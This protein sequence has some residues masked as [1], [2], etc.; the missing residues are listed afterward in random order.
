MSY[1]S[2]PRKELVRMARE[3]NITVCRNSLDLA[4]YI[5]R[6]D[7]GALPLCF[8][9]YTFCDEP[10]SIPLPPKEP[11]YNLLPLLTGIGG[12]LI[13][14]HLFP[15]VS[16]NDLMM[17]RVVCKI[18]NA[19]CTPY[20][21]RRAQAFFGVPCFRLF[22]RLSDMLVHDWNLE[23]AIRHIRGDLRAEGSV[24]ALYDR[25]VHEKRKSNTEELRKRCRNFRAKALD[26]RLLR[27]RNR[28]VYFDGV[29]IASQGLEREMLILYRFIYSAYQLKDGITFAD[30]PAI[31]AR[32]AESEHFARAKRSFEKKKIKR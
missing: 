4:T 1:L 30:V 28:S 25:H 8:Y 17:M 23:L 3:R 21:Q 16:I 19:L 7:R 18:F 29:P 27:F 2:R 9:N 26:A 24:T 6:H 15:F 13:A 22:G 32:Y 11:S 10:V 12:D 20:L 5:Y 31:L 14:M